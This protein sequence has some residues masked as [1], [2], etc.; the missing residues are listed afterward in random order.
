MV[1]LFCQNQCFT[2]KRGPT[3]AQQLMGDNGVLLVLVKNSI[4]QG[5]NVWNTA[6]CGLSL[7]YFRQKNM[8]RSERKIFTS[9]RCIFSSHRYDHNPRKKFFVT[10]SQFS[11]QK[12][13]SEI[14]F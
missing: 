1:E 8:G 9:E 3:V 2:G 7:P 10:L 5:G 12:F 4:G 14:D 13:I 6:Q 11:C